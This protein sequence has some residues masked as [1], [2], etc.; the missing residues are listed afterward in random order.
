MTDIFCF[1][2]EPWL[3]ELIDT[4][5]NKHRTDNKTQIVHFVVSDLK[6]ELESIKSFAAQVSRDNQDLRNKIASRPPPG[7]IMCLATGAEI[8][9]TMCKICK[10]S[11]KAYP[12]CPLKAGIGALQT[13]PDVRVTADKGV[14]FP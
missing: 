7:K 3:Q 12:N 1:R 4:A 10:L 11:R 13:I 14:T 9:E 2:P 8:A 6:G 5:R